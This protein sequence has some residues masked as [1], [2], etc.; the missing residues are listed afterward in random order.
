[1]ELLQWNEKYSVGIQSIDAQHQKW[2]RILNTL[3][4]ALRE[5]RSR[6]V[7]AALLD[8]MVR[9][10]QT[11]LNSEEKLMQQTNYPQYAEHKKIHDDLTK[12]VVEFQN[13]FQNGKSSLGI[14]MMNYLKTWL[15]DHIMGTDKLYGPH[16][17]QKGVK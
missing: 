8:E 14:E 5:G 2:I 1:M 11:H 9:Y 4:A 13:D 16:L 17:K 6:D 3:H 7:I 15:N 12:K 10:T